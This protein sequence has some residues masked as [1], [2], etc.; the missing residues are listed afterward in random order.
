[1]NLK[2]RRQIPKNEWAI[3][4]VL[5]QVQKKGVQFLRILRTKRL[6]CMPSAH[7]ISETNEHIS[8]KFSFGDLA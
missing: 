3:G 1:M 4:M 6:K 7:F 2:Q 8:M 5:R